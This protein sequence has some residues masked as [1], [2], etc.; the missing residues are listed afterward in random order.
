[1]YTHVYNVNEVLSWKPQIFYICKPYFFFHTLDP[2]C[3][4]CLRVMFVF[5]T[6]A[7]VV[8]TANHLFGRHIPFSLFMPISFEIVHTLLHIQNTDAHEVLS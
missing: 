3:I 5:F 6:N 1:M 7:C 4:P 2:L 8:C